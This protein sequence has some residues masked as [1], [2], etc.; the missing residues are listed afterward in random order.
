MVRRAI[1]AGCQSLVSIQPEA[2]RPMQVWIIIIIYFG[3]SPGHLDYYFSADSQHYTR[4]KGSMEG[5][6]VYNNTRILVQ[7]K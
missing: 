4:E 3:C 1:G 5:K 2:T 6:V 7:Y